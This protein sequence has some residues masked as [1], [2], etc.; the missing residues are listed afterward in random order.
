MPFQ[1]LPESVFDFSLEP[2]TVQEE[3]VAVTDISPKLKETSSNI[4]KVVHSCLVLEQPESACPRVSSMESLK[5]PTPSK[6]LQEAKKIK[7]K[8]IHGMSLFFI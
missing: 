8:D 7:S 4:F 2:D 6:A 3:E 5:F 1:P